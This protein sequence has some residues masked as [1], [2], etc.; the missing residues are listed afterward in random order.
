MRRRD[1]RVSATEGS[2]CVWAGLVS[3]RPCRRRAPYSRG[4]STA[5][6][7]LPLISS[8]KSE[9]SLCGA[10]VERTA[11]AAAAPASAAGP[12][13]TELLASCRHSM[14]TLTRYRGALLHLISLF[15]VPLSHSCC[16]TH[17][18]THTHTHTHTL[19]L[20]LSPLCFT[21]SVCLSRRGTAV[22]S[23]A[24]SGL[25]LRGRQVSSPPQ[26]TSL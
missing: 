13:S 4:E 25:A 20:S 17:T 7:P 12:S 26:I 11:R 16:N 6:S 1:T 22:P 2:N 15:I 10:A 3:A 21:L 24:G 5:L 9:K 23:I 18:Q 8:E 14:F 19:S